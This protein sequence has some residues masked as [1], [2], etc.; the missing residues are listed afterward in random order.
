[1][2]APSGDQHCA[3]VELGG[4]GMSGCSLLV[5]ASG[6]AASVSTPAWSLLNASRA[7]SGDQIG[8]Y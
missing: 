1:M 2:C 5:P 8:E 7:P 4:G 3:Y 6:F